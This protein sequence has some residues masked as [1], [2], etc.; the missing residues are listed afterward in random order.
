VL[1]REE[2]EVGDS[3][4]ISFRSPDSEDAAHL[5]LPHLL[6]EVGDASA[7]EH[8]PYRRALNVK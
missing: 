3:R 6:R 1:E 4:H 8:E 7:R 5:E 2:P